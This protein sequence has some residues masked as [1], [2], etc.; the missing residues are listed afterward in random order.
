MFNLIFSLIMGIAALVSVI[1]V[2]GA[3]GAAFW[4]GFLVLMIGHDIAHQFRKLNER[5]DEM[6]RSIECTIRI[7]RQIY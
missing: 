1:F 4:A 7:N 3:R 6:E 2:P 5:L